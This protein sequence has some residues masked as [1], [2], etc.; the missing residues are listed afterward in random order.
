LGNGPERGAGKGSNKTSYT[1]GSNMS[2]N[3]VS[4]KWENIA[5]PIIC[6]NVIIADGEKY[7]KVMEANN[8]LITKFC[9]NI[10]SAL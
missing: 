3:K 7:E 1:I 6:K 2:F 9:W 5:N 4:N 10:P 8:R